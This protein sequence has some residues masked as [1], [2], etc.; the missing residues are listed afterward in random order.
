MKKIICALLAV[1][2]LFAFTACG[3]K[4]APEK[5]PAP[6]ETL[7]VEG[8]EKDTDTD[9]ETPAPSDKPGD[10]AK[11]SA[12]PSSA[13]SAKPT[14][15]PTAKPT[16]TPKPTAKPTPTPAPTPAPVP[17]LSIYDVMS[18]IIAGVDLP[19]VGNT[20]VSSDL[21]S[22][23]LFINYIEGSEALAS[24]A[25]IGSIAHSVVLLHLPEGGDAA[26]AAAD[27]KANANPR[28]WICVEAEQV[29]VKTSGRYVLL[30]MS[31]AVTANAI[32]ANF[33]ALLG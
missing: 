14:P 3:K 27:I 24:E 2:M 22:S 23:Y 6:S 33:S 25:L 29:T 32:S 17:E 20:A 1:S 5:T 10:E 15:K 21:Y 26:T 4:S 12:A 7:K 9:K 28:K 13:P 30:V 31:D 18:S 16:P 8:A 11:A 19:K